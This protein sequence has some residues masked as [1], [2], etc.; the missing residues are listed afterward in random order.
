MAGMIDIEAFRADLSGPT[1]TRGDD[2]YDEAR[3]AWNG[4]INRYP[5]VIAHCRSAAD[6]AAAIG[7]ARQRTSKISVRGVSTTPRAPR[8]ATTE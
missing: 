5:A 1:L 8:S 2:G 4:E 6:V 7:F 3:S